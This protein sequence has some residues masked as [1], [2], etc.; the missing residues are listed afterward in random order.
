MHA[1]FNHAG[2]NNM[3]QDAQGRR[4]ILPPSQTPPEPD[5]IQRLK[6]FLKEY[7]QALVIGI[8]LVIA[9]IL[10]GIAFKNYRETSALRA[11]QLL[12]NARSAEE[13]QQ[14]ISQ[15]P[16]APVM[17]LAL[18]A[19]ASHRYDE[20]QYEMARN[21][22]AQLKEKFPKHPMA[23][24]AD[25]G[26][27]QCLEAEGQLE[28]ALQI[29][30]TFSAD[31]PKH[32]LTPLARFGKARCLH[33]LGRY[34]EARAEYE[35]FVAAYPDSEWSTV[36]ESAILFVEKD[37][38]AAAEVPALSSEIATPKPAAAART[39]ES[40]NPAQEEQSGEGVSSETAAGAPEP[41]VSKEPLPEETSRER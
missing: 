38:R 37:K 24:V 34:D 28:A 6:D 31:H 32:F 5:E 20:G 14:V 18:L 40:A 8:G 12:M 15:Y 1:I 10:G 3:A 26:R 33:Q 36:A 11:S 41:A 17:P 25:L 35:E 23:V 13:I 27:A 4:I 22:F 30:G 16:N 2:V 19:L 39:A 21:T 29:F 9:A 7:G